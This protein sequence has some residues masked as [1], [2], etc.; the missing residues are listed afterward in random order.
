VTAVLGVLAPVF[1]LIGLGLWLRRSGLAPEEHW[2]TVEQICFRLF[3]P[4]MIILSLERA[5]LSGA[6][7]SGMAGAMM[8][9][10]TLVGGATIVLRKPLLRLWGV[11]TP[12]YTTIFQSATRW[13]GFIALAVALELY[14]P[15]GGALVAVAMAA[16][17]PLVNVAN[18]TLMAMLLSSEGP[19]AKKI[20]WQ[21]AKN[22]LIQGCAIGLAINLLGVELWHPL[23]TLLDILGR[24]ALGA[25]LLAVG[26]GLRVRYALKP[27]REIW[28]SVA[29]KLALTP[30]VAA[31]AALAFGLSGEAFEIAMICAA[32]PTAMNGF[33]LAR[34]MGGD[35]ELYAGAVTVQTAIAALSMPV[36]ISLARALG[37]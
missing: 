16:L 6:A 3:F 4:A 32:V 15:E 5:D 25:G 35:A 23:H 21:I 27:S 26:A 36:I 9:S 20:L 33:I 30:L 1:G 31:M 22:P 11:E 2:R 19:D 28:L 37:G 14:G 8:V 24:G 18:V 10:A 29:L 7:V 17:I 12:A 13:N 34:Q